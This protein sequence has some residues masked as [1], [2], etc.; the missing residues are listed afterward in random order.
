MSNARTTNLPAAATAAEHN[1]YF[2][3]GTNNPGE[4]RGFDAIGHAIGTVAHNVRGR[5]EQALLATT[6]P[7][8]VDSGA[9]SEVKFPVGAAGRVC[10]PPVVVKEITDAVW[11][12]RIAA[13]RR[14]GAAM[15]S[16]LSVVAPDLVGSQERTL[17]R[18]RRYSFAMRGVFATGAEVLVPLQRGALSL[19]EMELACADALGV[20]LDSFVVAIPFKKSATSLESLEAY[21]TARQPRR[22][23][24]LGMGPGN[25]QAAQVFA[26]FARLAP[27]T[28]LTFDSCLIR[29]NVGRT[30]GPN[31]GPRKLT[32]ARDVAEAHL[33]S[34]GVEYS[35]EACKELA[36][37]IAFGTA[38]VLAPAA[39]VQLELF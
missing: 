6:V 25:R 16:R 11:L 37:Q 10:G 15:G 24:V 12:Q 26:L 19:V 5:V 22:V 1:A 14:L 28:V 32:I 21:L 29:A 4:I 23:H 17:D 33:A 7:V 38:P 27:E 9:F 2:A 3:S 36:I 34:I 31:N 35:S 39:P 13:Y 20:E 30:N 8:F 18:Q